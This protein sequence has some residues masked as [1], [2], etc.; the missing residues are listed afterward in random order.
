VIKKETIDENNIYSISSH[1][2]KYY[3]NDQIV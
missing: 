3:T 1:I 2:L